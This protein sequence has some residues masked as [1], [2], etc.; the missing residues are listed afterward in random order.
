MHLLAAGYL[1]SA[2]RELGY[3]QVVE[4]RSVHVVQLVVVQ[5]I[6][7]HLIVSQLIVPQLAVMQLVI[8]QPVAS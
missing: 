2:R 4:N 1:S 8:T 6:V 7:S 3:Q 5:L